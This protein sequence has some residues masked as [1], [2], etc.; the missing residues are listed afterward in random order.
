MTME[1]HH[2]AAIH[3]PQHLMLSSESLR[4]FPDRHACACRSG[5]L[6]SGE[7]RQCGGAGRPFPGAGHG[8]AASGA[9]AGSGHARPWARGP[10]R[11]RSDRAGTDTRAAA[12]GPG[13][14]T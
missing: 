8:C 12:Q 4:A 1:P 7:A 5:A 11:W 9:R 3:L 2:H 6:G 13:A 14:H 10:A